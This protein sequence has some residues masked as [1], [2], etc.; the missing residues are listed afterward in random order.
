MVNKM[1]TYEDMPQS[2]QKSY[3]LTNTIRKVLMFLG[4]IISGG[5]FLCGTFSMIVYQDFSFGEVLF[6]TYVTGG[7]ILGLV[8][9]EFLFKSLFKSIW[10]LFLVGIFFLGFILT[11]A[12][13]AGGAYLIIDTILFI[14]KKPLIY[15]FENKYFLQTAQAQAEMELDYQ[16]SMVNAV[17]TAATAGNGATAKN[18]LQHLKDMLDQGLITEAEFNKKKKELLERI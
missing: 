12:I 4:W 8:H 18:D 2:A 1:I 16:K 7:L 5:F 17:A 6:L 13:F 10:I 11:Y 9:C 3:R 15:S 14:R